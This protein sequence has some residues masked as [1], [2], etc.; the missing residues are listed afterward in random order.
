[1]ASL[2]WAED[3]ILLLSGST[4]LRPQFVVLDFG[5]ASPAEEYAQQWGDDRVCR[6]PDLDELYAYMKLENGLGRVATAWYHI[7][8]DRD[9][10]WLAHFAGHEHHMRMEDWDEDSGEEES[11]A[12]SED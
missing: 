3:D 1:M 4:P 6:W 2:R 5:N 8:Y 7:A 11:R 9:P 12:D 10:T